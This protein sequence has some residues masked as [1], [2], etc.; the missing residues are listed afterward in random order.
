M[1]FAVFGDFATLV[2]VSLHLCFARCW[3]A[4]TLRLSLFRWSL[5]CWSLSGTQ[6]TQARQMSADF[7]CPSYE[8]RSLS[9]TPTLLNKGC[10]GCTVQL[11]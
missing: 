10:G 3:V 4:T 11:L 1:C 8:C 9:Y 5:L 7:I 2:A 6:I